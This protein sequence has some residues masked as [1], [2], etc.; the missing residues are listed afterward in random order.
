MKETKNQLAY[1]EFI[2][3]ETGIAY[4]GKTKD[5]ASDYISRNKDKIPASG[6]INMWAL[7]NGY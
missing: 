5:E 2:E 3:S 7:V 4:K 1:I 6:F